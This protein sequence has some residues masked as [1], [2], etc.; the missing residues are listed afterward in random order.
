MKDKD[1]HPQISKND[2]S[3]EDEEIIQLIDEVVENEDEEVTELSDIASVSTQSDDTPEGASETAEINIP[4][5]KLERALERVIQRTF[6]EKAEQ[7]LTE[8]IEKAVAKEI[9]K[10]KH[11]LLEDSSGEEKT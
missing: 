2:G 3:I 8:V 6:S 11:I 4:D 10:L 9:E 7:M 1:G 5:E